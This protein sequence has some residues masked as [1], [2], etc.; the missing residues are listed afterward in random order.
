MPNSPSAVS[1][2]PAGCWDKDW[3]RATA[4]L[5]WHVMLANPAIR[6]VSRLAGVIPIESE[7]AVIS[8]LAAGAAVLARGRNLVWFP[9]GMRSRTGRLQRFQPGIGLLVDHFNVP[10]GPVWLTGTYEALAPGR[11]WPRPAKI[12]V[13]IGRPL[14]PEQLRQEGKGE[15]PHQRITQALRRRMLELSDQPPP[16]PPE[17]HQNGEG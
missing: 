2:L 17:R 11:F 3:L 5:L 10:V 16:A 4:S 15:A 6:L 1:N 12:C 13:R 9:E 8:S 7:R 14:T